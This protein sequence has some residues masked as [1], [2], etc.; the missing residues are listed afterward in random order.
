MVCSRP[1][2]FLLK[3]RFGFKGEMVALDWDEPW[4]YNG[5]RIVLVPAGHV[6][7]SAMIHLTRLSDGA[8]LLYTGDFKLRHGLTAEPARPRPAE[9]RWISFLPKRL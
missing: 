8:T 2:A 3:E 9:T 1:T 7:G 4:E 6:R 5:H